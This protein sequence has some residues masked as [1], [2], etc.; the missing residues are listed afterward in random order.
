[1]PLSGNILPIF[2][3]DEEDS[4]SVNICV[5]VVEGLEIL[6]RPITLMLSTADLTATS[7]LYH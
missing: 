7:K 2:S 5:E 6:C 4:S 3:V 1:M